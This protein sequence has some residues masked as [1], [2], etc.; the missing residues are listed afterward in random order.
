M[1]ASSNAE[2]KTLQHSAFESPKRLESNR[3]P[4]PSP[5]SAFCKM[6]KLLMYRADAQNHGKDRSTSKYHL[7]C[8][9]SL[10][11]LQRQHLILI[12]PSVTVSPSIGRSFAVAIRKF[13]PTANMTIAIAMRNG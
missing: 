13:L 4:G 9:L 11:P 10:C 6:Y 1:H 12:M 5:P 3:F 7:F 2:L 8:R